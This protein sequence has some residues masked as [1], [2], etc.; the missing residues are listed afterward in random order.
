MNDKFL[1][2]TLVVYI[3]KEIALTFNPESILD[4]SSL[5]ECH[6]QF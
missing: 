4:F 6:A 1:I 2:D 3:K 5:K